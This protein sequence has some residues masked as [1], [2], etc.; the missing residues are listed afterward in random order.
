MH[1]VQVGLHGNSDHHVWLDIGY[2]CDPFHILDTAEPFEQIDIWPDATKLVHQNSGC[3]ERPFYRLYFFVQARSPLV[4][5]LNQSRLHFSRSSADYAGNKETKVRLSK[6]HIEP[7]I[8]QAVSLSD[9]LLL[10]DM[11]SRLQSMQPFA[12]ETLIDRPSDRSHYV[13]R[14]VDAEVSLET[15]DEEPPEDFRPHLSFGLRCALR[16]C[17]VVV[18]HT[19]DK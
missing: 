5:M 17:D 15:A 8:F 10:D 16:K 11:T 18:A 3:R 2:A 12:K 6:V 9:V 13:D 7:N 4:V 19:E 14:P 1:H